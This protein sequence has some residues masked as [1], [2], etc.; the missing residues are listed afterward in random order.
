MLSIILPSR[1]ER[2]LPNTIAD[3]LAKAEGDI[4]IIAV[5]E[6]YWP[7]PLP[8][9]DPRV[10][11]IHF[12][13]PKG[14]RAALN[15]GVDIAS[16]EFVMKLDAHCMFSQGFD[17]ALT[18]DCRNNWVM[19]PTRKRL[20]P[21]KWVVRNHRE[22]INYLYCERPHGDNY[23]LN[24]KEWRQ[25]NKDKKLQ[26][27]LLDDIIIMQGS[28]YMMP[29]DYWYFLELLD[30]ENYGTFRKDPQEVSFKSWTS[31]GRVVRS[32][33]AWYAH[34]HKG[35][36]YRRGYSLARKDWDKGDLYVKNWL[37][38]TA[39][40]S[41][42]EI[43]RFKWVIQHFSDMPGWE[44]HEWVKEK[45]ESQPQEKLALTYQHLELP[46]GRPLTKTPSDRTGS[47][48]WNEGKFENFV[49]PLLPEDVT[50]QVF[51]EMGCDAGLYLRMAKDYGYRHVI[52]VEK[53]KTPVR[54]G[55]KYRDA[56]GYDYKILKRKLG[57]QFGEI[58][59]FNIDEL[60][61][62]DI[63]LM[64]NWHYHIDINAWYN[65]YLPK[66]PFKTCYVLIVSTPD[67]VRYH[68]HVNGHLGYLEKYFQ[69]WEKV[70]MI[71]IEDVPQE[72]DPKPRRLFSVL[73]KSPF[74]RRVPIDAIARR[75]VKNPFAE[76]GIKELTRQVAAGE[77]IKIPET[78]LYEDWKKRKPNWSEKTLR[79]FC[80]GKLGLIKNLIQNWPK[81]P[82]LVQ[83]DTLLLSDGGHRLVILEELGYKTVIVR[84]I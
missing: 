16:G 19:V 30:E 44:D 4:E 3:L 68:W 33:K 21:E 27:V 70:G 64:S 82:I 73:Y 10:K 63:T 43:R 56:L 20:D 52:G 39:W 35:K 28:C 74:I 5:L 34:L 50:D 58:G 80:Q 83:K 14:M 84:E 7:N 42:K 76:A 77:K 71:N 60:P 29:R 66:L 38:D 51:V 36:Q 65:H 55:R 24:G 78:A 54:A 31:G 75:K 8:P 25:K 81:D 72:G 12:S 69:G 53:N 59:T 1:N 48:F 62:A 79:V 11:Y 40:D 57:G 23:Q 47:R 67:L 15:A 18:A 49:Q 32:K 45:A 41:P 22:D 9:D 26:E 13:K 6:G 37:D 61:I 2:F 46:N 17:V